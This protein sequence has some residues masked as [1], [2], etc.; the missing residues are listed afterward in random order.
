MVEV[1]DVDIE[2]FRIFLKWLVLDS[3]P[4]NNI[5]GPLHTNPLG[6]HYWTSGMPLIKLYILGS[7]YDIPQ[8]AADALR[9]FESLVELSGHREHIFAVDINVIPTFD[10]VGYV[11]EHTAADSPLRSIIVNAVCNGKGSL[12]YGYMNCS[13]EFLIDVIFQYDK[14]KHTWQNLMRYLGMGDGELRTKRKRRLSDV[15]R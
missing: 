3:D 10:E 14:E 4:K 11:Y 13:R 12:D 5:F 15:G 6:G 8:L 7:N 1:N 2:T 9:R